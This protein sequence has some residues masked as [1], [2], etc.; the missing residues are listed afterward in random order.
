MPT[1]PPHRS[2]IHNA[3]LAAALFSMPEVRRAPER[4]PMPEPSWRRHNTTTGEDRSVHPPRIV[5]QPS[6]SRFKARA[7][8]CQCP[9]TPGVQAV[10]H[11][12]MSGFQ[13]APAFDAAPNRGSSPLELWRNPG[14]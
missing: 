12:Q 11:R 6:E 7:E 1:S 10:I 8:H 13:S 4:E 2:H 9:R 14:C 5:R 3:R